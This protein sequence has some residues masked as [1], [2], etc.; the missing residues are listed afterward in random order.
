MFGKSVC[1]RKADITSFF[2]L[3][4]VT[5]GQSSGNKIGRKETRRS[6]LKWVVALAMLVSTTVAFQA[7][8]KSSRNYYTVNFKLAFDGMR[9]MQ[10]SKTCHR[11]WKC[12]LVEDTGGI[13]EISLKRGDRLEPYIL[14]STPSSCSFPSGQSRLPLANEVRLD[15]RDGKDDPYQ[16]VIRYRETI[17]Y[18]V[19]SFE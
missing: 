2:D 10:G 14:C 6:V 16:A 11:D 4:A 8:A 15:I 5:V 3:R 17:G 9:M 1:G 7:D 13:S 18:L 12:V 19:L